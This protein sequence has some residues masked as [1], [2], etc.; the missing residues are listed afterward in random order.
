MGLNKQKYISPFLGVKT[1][2]IKVLTFVS[3][4]FQAVFVESFEMLG[5]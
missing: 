5:V 4:G 3:W 2:R 1:S